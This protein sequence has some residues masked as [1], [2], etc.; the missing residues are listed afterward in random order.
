MMDRK[1]D[2]AS[3][4]LIADLRKGMNLCNHAMAIGSVDKTIGALD[5]LIKVYDEMKLYPLTSKFCGMIEERIDLVN[6][7]IGIVVF[8]EAKRKIQNGGLE[9]GT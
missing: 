4:I 7:C 9:N 3:A 8:D 5:E 1:I 6:Q 2:Y